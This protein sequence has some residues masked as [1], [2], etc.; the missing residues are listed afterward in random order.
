MEPERRCKSGM[1]GGPRA[2]V[3]LSPL[4]HLRMDVFLSNRWGPP[5]GPLAAAGFHVLAP[6]LRGYGR[7]TGWDERYDTDLR[8]FGLLNYARDALALVF[9]FGYIGSWRRRLSSSLICWSLVTSRFFAGCQPIDGAVVLT[10][11][12]EALCPARRG[13]QV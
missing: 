8:P 13:T 2:A 5:Q 9:A 10:D 7:T 11:Q 4:L 1:D 6:D 3:L 12:C